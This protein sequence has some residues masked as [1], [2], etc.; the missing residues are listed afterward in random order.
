[1]NI[2]TNGIRIHYTIEGEGPPI[3][4]LHG[5]TLDRSFWDP[6]V[7]ALR[8]RY[9]VIAPDL[10]GF[11]QSELGNVQTSSMELMAEDVRALL[12]RI[13]VREPVVLGGLSMGVAV[14][15]AFVGR[16]PERIRALFLADGRATVDTAEAHQARLDLAERVEREN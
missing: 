5:Y 6:H 2:E 13:A 15:L 9:R 7:R 1:M 14:T 8:R 11:G 10:R 12:D 16:Y 3:V 4:L